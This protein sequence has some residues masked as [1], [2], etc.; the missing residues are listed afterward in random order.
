MK[1][2]GSEIKIRENLLFSL[3]RYPVWWL[4]IVIT[5]IFDYLTT[6]YFVGKLGP[7]AEANHFIGWLIVN[8]GLFFGLFIGKLVQLFSV[9]FFVCMSQRLGNLF[10]LVII[11]MNCWAVVI[12]TIPHY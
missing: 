10:L 9:I 6:L 4:I 11:L 8:V 3:K 5:M 12:N 1:I 2:L 7:Q